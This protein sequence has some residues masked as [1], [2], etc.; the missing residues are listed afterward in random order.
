MDREEALRRTQSKRKDVV[1]K[2][3]DDP[4]TEHAQV[5]SGGRTKTAKVR[6]FSAVPSEWTPLSDSVS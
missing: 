6:A 1:V 5:H 4:F 2:D 3:G